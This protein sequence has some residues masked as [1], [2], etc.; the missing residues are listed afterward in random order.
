MADA[1]SRK[2]RKSP[3]V[4]LDT[5]GGIIPLP[6]TRSAP[7]SPENCRIW[8]D[9]RR[10]FL[11]RPSIPAD[12]PFFLRLPSLANFGGLGSECATIPPF[13]PPL[14]GKHDRKGIQ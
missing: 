13:T 10:L 3:P 2:G 5:P 14:D 9:W 11:P 4:A 12:F 8:T 7:S 6:D 1:N